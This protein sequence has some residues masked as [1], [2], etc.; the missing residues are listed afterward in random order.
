MWRSIL[1][2]VVGILV[3]GLVVGLL[4]LPGYFIHPLP[5]GFDM[6]NAEA[7]KGH[8]AK[9]PLAALVG[10]AVAWSIGPFVGAFLAAFIAQRAFLAHGLLIGVFFMAM[11]LIN[12]FSFPH[13]TW[14]LLVGVI[15]PLVSGYLGASLAARFTRPPPT[16]PQPYDMRE[17]NMAC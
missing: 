13:P 5:P 6:A 17:K 1:A 8:F 2:I 12:I 14:L 9:A 7:L 11:D 4:E 15:A 3:G 10:V 16:S